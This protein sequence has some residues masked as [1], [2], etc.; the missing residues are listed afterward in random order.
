MSELMERIRPTKGDKASRSAA[1]L[2]SGRPPRLRDS[3]QRTWFWWALLVA[4]GV[5]FPVLSDSTYIYFLAGGIGVYCLVGVGMNLLYGLGGQVSL[6]QGAIVAV[7]SYTAGI[8]LVHGELDMWTALVIATVVGAV[9]GILMGLPSLR[10]S[11]WYFALTTLA[12]GELV[13]GLVEYFSEYTGGTNGLV[14]IFVDLTSGELY[15]VIVAANVVGLALYFTFVNSR[16]G[17]GLIAIKEGGEAGT[18]SGVRTISIKVIVFAISGAYAGA[19]GALFAY[20]Q[21]VIAPDQFTTNFSIFFIVIIVAGGYGRWLGPVIGALAFFAVPELLTDLNEWRMVIYG[22][23]LLL[24]MAFAPNGIMGALEALW[25]R[26]RG[27]TPKDAAGPGS[28][29][30][31][32]AGYDEDLEVSASAAKAERLASLLRSA[33]APDGSTDIGR[34]TVDDVAVSFGGVKALQGVSMT[35]DSGK[36]YGLVGPNGSGKTTLLNVITGIYKPSTGSVHLHGELLTGVAPSKLAALGIARTFQTPRLLKDLSV[37]ENVMLGG[38]TAEKSSSLEVLLRIGRARKESRRLGARAY[39]LLDVLGLAEHAGTR[40]GDLPHGLQRM[41]EIARALM[42][43][44]RLLLLDEPAAGLSADELQVLDQ[45]VRNLGGGGVTVLLVEHHIG[46]VRELC[47]HVTVLDQGKV[48][49]AG[50]PETVFVD[51]RVRETYL[52]VLG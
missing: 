13:L 18:V 30:S 1:R 11:T 35:L 24:F 19:A 5:V 29:S 23:A 10:L 27:R 40:A 34:L 50:D 37:W 44:P 31:G 22:A 51:P 52:G 49:T 21:Q 26:V 48:V 16:L 2:A 42:V 36:I 32:E 20:E 3:L 17:R 46:W 41:L 47:E 15:W 7:G 8:A 39:E 38:Y 45:L 12:F 28:R 9:T 25:A 14:G 6:G 33:E 43:Q 4:A